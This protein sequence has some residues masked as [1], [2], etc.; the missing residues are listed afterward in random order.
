MSQYAHCPECD[1]RIHLTSVRL[2][3]RVTCKECNATS[4]VVSINPLKLDWVDDDLPESDDRY[5]QDRYI[6]FEDYSSYEGSSE[7]DNY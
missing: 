3:L 4:E 1:A 6:P 5:S 7:T 2:G